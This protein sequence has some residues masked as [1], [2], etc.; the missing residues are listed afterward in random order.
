MTNMR[1]RIDRVT[2]TVNTWI[3]GDND[4]VIVIDAGDDAAS[5]LAAVGDRSVLAVICPHG[6]ARHTSAAFEVAKPDD[7][8][9][10]L[11]SGDVLAWREAHPGT[12]PDIEME[13][14]GI[15]ER[16]DRSL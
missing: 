3:V 16:A 11:H 7:A 15:V 10:A 4:E 8:P 13:D 5:V 6:H 2:R 14:G 12:Q 1:A 9:V